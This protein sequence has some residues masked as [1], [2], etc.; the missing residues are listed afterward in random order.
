MSLQVASCGAA[1]HVYPKPM[2]CSQNYGPFRTLKLNTYC[3]P[4]ISKQITVICSTFFFW[5]TQLRTI[6]EPQTN[7]GGAK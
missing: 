4:W 7:Q 5:A 2:S 1:A 3:L 6:K